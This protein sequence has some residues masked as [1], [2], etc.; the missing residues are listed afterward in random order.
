MARLIRERDEAKQSYAS[1]SEQIQAGGGAAAMQVDGGA[2]GKK[3]ER[4]ADEA[5]SEGEKKTKSGVSGDVVAKMTARAKALSKGRRKKPLPEGLATPEDLAAFALRG[6][7]P[8]HAAS[9]PG[10]GIL[11]L[12]S[13]EASVVTGGADGKF[14]VFDLESQQ[15]VGDAVKAHAKP[16]TCVKLLGSAEGTGSALDLVG[17]CSADKT[18]KIWKKAGGSYELLF[19]LDEDAAV[20]LDRQATGDYV[21][22]FHKSG[23][24]AFHALEDGAKLATASCENTEFTCGNFHPDG[25]ILATGTA[26]GDVLI[27]DVKEQKSVATFQGHKSAIAS[28][29]FSENGYY[30]ATTSVDAEEGVKL[31]DLRKLQNF[32]TI[33]VRGQASGQKFGKKAPGVFAQ[34][35]SSGAFLA[36][37]CGK[38]AQIYGAKQGW[39]ALLPEAAGFADVQSTAAKGASCLGFGAL[40]KTLFVGSSADHNL[41]VYGGASE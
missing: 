3:R 35:D 38:S 31:W 36:V 13:D 7:F 22:V 18:C 41:R 10:R 19:A 14:K 23:S 20:G 33:D 26:S 6:K 39:K 21:V 34:F 37:G 4:E 32:H 5:A 28:V 2:G 27:W 25:L 9:G 11:C 17:T 30:L 15:A 40:A 12:D 16:I 8:L 29:S 1:L 24:W